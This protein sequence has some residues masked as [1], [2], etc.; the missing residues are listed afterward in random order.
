MADRPGN[1][2]LRRTAAR[3]RSEA[4]T[5]PAGGNPNPVPEPPADGVL[6]G[7][8]GR[9]W[10]EWAWTTPQ[11]TQW[12]NPYTVLHRAKLEDHMAVS[13]ERT[14]LSIECRQLDAA[15][16]LSAKAM[17]DLGWVIES[18]DEAPRRLDAPGDRARRRKL[19]VV[20]AQAAAS[21]Q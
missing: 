16:G 11:S 3:A 6:L 19:T 9:A 12:L 18:D 5:L 15:L 1:S 8:A 14:K 7:D 20:D 13:E 4:V 17:K 10:W 2:A 21:N